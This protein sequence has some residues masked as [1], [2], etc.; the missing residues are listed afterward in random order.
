MFPAAAS[1]HNSIL[2]HFTNESIWCVL[3]LRTSLRVPERSQPVSS[4]VPTS[5][6]LPKCCSTLGALRSSSQLACLHLSLYKWTF[7]TGISFSASLNMYHMGDALNAS[8]PSELFANRHFW[9]FTT[10]DTMWGSVI[11]IELLCCRSR[12]I[13][14]GFLRCFSKTLAELRLIQK[15]CAWTSRQRSLHSLTYISTHTAEG[16]QWCDVLLGVLTNPT[17]SQSQIISEADSCGYSWTG[18][19]YICFLSEM[20]AWASLMFYPS[21]NV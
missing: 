12:E 1:S 5:P 10:T 4:A 13:R 18:E 2:C 21:Y 6:G 20:H 7:N 17:L 3:S 8:R 16:T 19:R 11:V 9:G 15:C 14:W